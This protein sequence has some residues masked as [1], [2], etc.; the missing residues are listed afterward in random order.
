MKKFLLLSAFTLLMNCGW[1]GAQNV[2][3]TSAA[4]PCVGCFPAGWV[5]DA[6]PNNFAP[7][8]S[9]DHFYGGD[10]GRAWVPLL[11]A[12]PS[13]LGNFLSSYNTLNGTE[14]S[15]TI[16][17]GLTPFKTYY[18]KY[19][20]MSSKTSGTGYGSQGK[21]ALSQG[22][23]ATDLTV[24]T[25][26][27]DT[28]VWIKKTLIFTPTSHTAR[29][30]FSGSSDVNGYV[31][32]DIGFNALT[33]C[34][35]GTDQV[36]LSGNLLTTK[37]PS[38]I[39][40]NLMSLVDDVAPA[41]STLVWFTNP[42]HSQQ[43]F[44]FPTQAG[45]GTYYAFFYDDNTGCY[46]TSLSSSKIT[47]TTAP[48][49]SI[50]GNSLTNVCKESAVNLN[51]MLTGPIPANATVAWFTNGIHSGNKVEIPTAVSS[52]T[53]Y[54][55]YHY[56]NGNCYNQDFSSS[57]VEVTI[58]PCDPDLTPTIDINSLI[59]NANV[60]RDFV[61]NI[62]E[63]NN[64]NTVGNI[65]FRINKLG[66][67]TISYPSESGVSN[68]F[69]G[70]T[71]NN[72]NWTFTENANY[73]TASKSSAILGNGKSIIGFKIKRKGGIPAGTSQNIKATIVGGTGGDIKSS[74]NAVITSVITN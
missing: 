8:I 28:D 63:I 10:Q 22:A 45:T 33:E 56:A 47:V 65:S 38:S 19:H 41:G 21:L 72:S 15:H 55:Y 53:Y 6:I 9:N 66:G 42:T 13:G 27:V 61:V 51:S 74:N 70:V 44:A 7:S 48:Q 4:N 29:L 59:F 64:L 68:V 52:G 37:C 39:D 1:V 30:T 43:E 35:A 34:S 58:K 23:T 20:I 36:N 40:A 18:L 49:V 67:F 5:F 25:P 3:V 26:N 16:I 73:I 62:Y 32:L 60:S 14:T 2:K 46:N 69:G 54:A 50:N 71:N 24:F 31:N 12:P 11:N 57:K 17:T